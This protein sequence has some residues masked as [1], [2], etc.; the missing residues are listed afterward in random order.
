MLKS[1]QKMV[2]GT[3][4][5]EQSEIVIVKALLHVCLHHREDVS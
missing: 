1:I 2:V 5:R 4:L 3:C